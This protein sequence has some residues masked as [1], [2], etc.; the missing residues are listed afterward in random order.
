M[1]N[2]DI[3]DIIIKKLIDKNINIDEDPVVIIDGE[4]ICCCPEKYRKNRVTQVFEKYSEY[5]NIILVVK[6]NGG[7]NRFETYTGVKVPDNYIYIS[8]HGDNNS[9]PDDAFIIE[10]AT[11]I[12]N[13]IIVTN[14][15]YKNR[16]NFKYGNIGKGIKIT[17]NLD[18]RGRYFPKTNVIENYKVMKTLSY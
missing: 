17:T 18:V 7:K 1:D 4:N 8:V 14:D 6:K 13:P 15:E 5:N 3:I 2:G 11:R 9:S 12:N 10:L 16:I